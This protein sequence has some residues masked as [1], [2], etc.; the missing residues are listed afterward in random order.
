MKLFK[1]KCME[2]IEDRAE[3]MYRYT[4]DT[5]KSC[6]TIFNDIKIVMKNTKVL[7]K[8]KILNKG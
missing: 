4:F 7:K 3:R 1:R 6:Y 5:G 8:F 2:P